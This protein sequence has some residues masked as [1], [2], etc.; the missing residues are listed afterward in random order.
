MVARG[1]RVP[2]SREPQPTDPETPIEETTTSLWPLAVHFAVV[3]GLTG[4]MLGL[5]YLLGQRHRGGATGD[6]YESGMRTTGPAHVRLSADFYMVALLFVIF[7]LEV[8]FLFAWAVAA[9][10]LGWAGYAGVLAFTLILAV[11]LVYEWRRGALDW[12]W[13]AEAKERARR[14]REA[15]RRTLEGA[16]PEDGGEERSA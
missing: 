10:T 14:A 11:G 6:P 5:S 7:D 15:S 9:R 16:V 3:V 1:R 4:A 8:A 2:F 12:G 13:A